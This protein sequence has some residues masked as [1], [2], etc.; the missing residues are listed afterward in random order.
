MVNKPRP[1][2]AEGSDVA[3][4]GLCLKLVKKWLKLLP[5]SPVYEGFLFMAKSRRKNAKSIFW[6]VSKLFCYIL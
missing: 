1:T 5:Q 3:N 6:G 4:A 2:R